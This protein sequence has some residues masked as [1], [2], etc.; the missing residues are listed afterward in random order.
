MKKTRCTNGQAWK[1]RQLGFLQPEIDKMNF[2]AAS[3]AIDEA[4]RGGQ[5]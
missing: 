5:A 1:L 2:D 4:T 3:K